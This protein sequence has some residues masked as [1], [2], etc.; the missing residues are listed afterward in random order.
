MKDGLRGRRRAR[1]LAGVA[2]ASAAEVLHGKEGHGAGH[3]DGTPPTD[4]QRD[5]ME[6]FVGHA[7]PIIEAFKKVAKE[8]RGKNTAA[9]GD[10]G[11][12]ELM[13][14]IHGH[15]KHLDSSIPDDLDDDKNIE[16]LLGAINFFS[17]RATAIKDLKVPDVPSAKRWKRMSD[18]KKRKVREESDKWGKLFAGAP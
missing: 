13:G 8:L 1:G 18:E 9:M 11:L 5:Y 7:N 6:D 3:D 10:T 14:K 12:R 4:A 2:P 15:M 17:T 16:Q